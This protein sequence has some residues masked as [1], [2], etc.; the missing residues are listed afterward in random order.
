[1]EDFRH[2]AVE[3]PVNFV[4]P[5][6]QDLITAT[7]QSAVSSCIRPDTGIEIVLT[8]VDFDDETRLAAFKIDNVRANRRLAA[9]MKT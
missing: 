7:L 5:E 9:K 4:V 3:I 8:A 6:S 1:L 2:H